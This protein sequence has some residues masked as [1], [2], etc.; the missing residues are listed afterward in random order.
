MR[1]AGVQHFAVV[2]D[3]DH[4]IRIGPKIVFQPGSPLKV[5]I[6]G[7]LV[8]QQHIRLGKQDARNGRAHPPATGE[9]LRRAMQIFRREAKAHQNF[10]GT[11]LTRPCINV[12]KAFMD[13][14]DTIRIGRSFRFRH[15]R[16][17]FCI[18]FQN[19]FENGL[20]GRRNFLRDPTER[21][22]LIEADGFILAFT[23]MRLTDQAEQ[24]RLA[25][26][27]APDKADLPAF[28]KLCGRLLEQGACTKS[29]GEVCDR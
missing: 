12:Q 1:H 26:S 28:R 6:V 21:R 18:C 3:E 13:F 11:R 4:R 16:M 27:V 24:C 5:E 7:R 10:A 15:Q 17:T 22:A 25:C 19:D 9:F 23:V 8:E 14:T 2:A 20:V 29:E